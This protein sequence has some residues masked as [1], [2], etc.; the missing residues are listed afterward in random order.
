ML[1]QS[2][3]IL[4][5]AHL[6]SQVA[7]GKDKLCANRRQQNTGRTYAIFPI[8]LDDYDH[9]DVA[10]SPSRLVVIDLADH[11]SDRLVVDIA[12][13]AELWPRCQKQAV[14]ED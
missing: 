8:L 4:A 6:R 1:E 10:S 9:A 2:Q 11:H 12:K 14:C 5:N 3:L 7:S 13:V